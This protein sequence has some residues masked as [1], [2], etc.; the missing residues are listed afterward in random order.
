MTVIEIT[1][2]ILNTSI[3]YISDKNVV[4]MFICRLVS[5]GMEETLRH[6]AYSFRVTFSKDNRLLVLNL[7]RVTHRTQVSFLVNI[8]NK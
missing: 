4:S 6:G 3:M 8:I 7:L 5:F 1:N 2:T